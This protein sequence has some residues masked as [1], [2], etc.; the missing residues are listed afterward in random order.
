MILSQIADVLFLKSNMISFL[1]KRNDT[2]KKFVE[3][4]K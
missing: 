2:I 4:D 1:K 3:L